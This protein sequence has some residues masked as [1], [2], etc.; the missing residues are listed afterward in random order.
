MDHIY[1]PSNYFFKNAQNFSKR[2]K[3][4]KNRCGYPTQ[5]KLSGTHQLIKLKIDYPK[6]WGSVQQ[7]K[8]ANHPQPLLP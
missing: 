4:R 2:K 3:N 6:K 7:H 1:T 5:A 8:H